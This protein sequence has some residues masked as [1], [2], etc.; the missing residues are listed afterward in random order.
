M[1]K[2]Y[3]KRG[4]LFYLEKRAQLTLFI[5]LAIMLVVAI[6]ILFYYLQPQ[7]FP[8][9]EDTPRLDNCISKSLDEEIKKLALNAGLVE[10][11]FQQMYMGKNYTFLCYTDEYHKPCVN[12][13]PLIV[14]VFEE[15]LKELLYNEFQE[16]YDSTVEDLRERGYEVSPGKAEFNLSILPGEIKIDIDAPMSISSGE[17]A[18]SRQDYSYKYRTNL[19]E[20]LSVVISLVQFETYYGDSEQTAQ[21]MIYPKIRIDKTRIDNGVKVYNVREKDEEIDYLFAVK[22]YPWPAGGQY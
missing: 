4:R 10:P 3:K 7:I 9:S 19:Y 13:V 14:G 2:E 15:S 21:M 20:L 5:I 1:I 17:S 16:C 11:E 22:S 18:V 8:S 12:Q 6:G